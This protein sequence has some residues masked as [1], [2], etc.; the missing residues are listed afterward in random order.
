VPVNCH[1][2]IVCICIRLSSSYHISSY[3]GSVGSHWWTNHG[4]Y[5]AVGLHSHLSVRWSF[6]LIQR[7]VVSPKSYIRTCRCCSGVSVVPG[8]SG[9]QGGGSLHQDFY[10][11]LFGYWEEL[12]TMEVS[13]LDSMFVFALEFQKQ[14]DRWNLFH[15]AM[16]LRPKFEALHSSWVHTF[17][18]FFFITYQYLSCN[19]SAK[20][21]AL[22]VYFAEDNHGE[23]EDKIK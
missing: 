6:K 4:I 13:F 7:A 20:F 5:Y 8:S 10:S 2:I 1:S 15:F 3:S 17:I 18:A 21:L 11:L 23:K 9:G 14:R 12:Q 22:N 16:R 19:K